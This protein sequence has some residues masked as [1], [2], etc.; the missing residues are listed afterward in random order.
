MVMS[1][2]F[3][4]SIS[5]DVFEAATLF[6]IYFFLLVFVGLLIRD[7]SVIPF[8][9]LEITQAKVVLVAC[10]IRLQF[11]GSFQLIN[12]SF[13]FTY[14]TVGHPEVEPV[15]TEFCIFTFT[16]IYC[17]MFF[18]RHLKVIAGCFKFL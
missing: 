12:T 1:E 8:F 14:T 2:S 18:N 5:T 7:Y 10:L 11:V 4:V 17:N 6:F 13:K 16:L 3:V 15:A 9:T